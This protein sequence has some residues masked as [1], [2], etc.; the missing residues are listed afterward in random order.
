M[1]FRVVGSGLTLYINDAPMIWA[2]DAALT[3][4][5]S[6]GL[7]QGNIG[8]VSATSG[9]QFTNFGA[10]SVV[11]SVVT[12]IV[13]TPVPIPAWTPSGAAS[14][15]WTAGSQSSTSWTPLL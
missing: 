10:E 11:G 6:V 13:T 1:R 5:G 12:S 4:A 14:A 2:T 9:L 8:S 3:A 7:A 15:T